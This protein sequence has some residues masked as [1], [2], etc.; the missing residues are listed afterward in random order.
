VA[1]RLFG[2]DGEI[3]YPPFFDLFAFVPLSPYAIEP[4][5]VDLQGI[6]I[7]Q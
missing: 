1:Q 3:R 4:F 7:R 2:K 5:L 6:I